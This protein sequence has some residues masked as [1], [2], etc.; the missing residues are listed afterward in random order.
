MAADVLIQHTLDGFSFI[1][2]E[3]WCSRSCVNSVD[4]HCRFIRPP[5]YNCMTCSEYRRQI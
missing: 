3:F 5:R 1:S 2:Q 4:G